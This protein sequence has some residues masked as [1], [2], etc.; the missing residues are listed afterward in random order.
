MHFH[1]YGR[2]K[3]K[4]AN[5]KDASL[6]KVILQLCWTPVLLENLEVLNSAHD[7]GYPCE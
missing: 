5:S 3:K 6:N 2:Y 7:R 4:T 1:F